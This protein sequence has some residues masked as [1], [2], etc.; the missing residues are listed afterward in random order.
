MEIETILRD[1]DNEPNWRHEAAESMDFYDSLQLTADELDILEERGMEPV[2][3]NVIFTGINALLGMEEK[4]RQDWRIVAGDEPDAD[5][6]VALS[7]KLNEE[8]RLSGSDRACSD[9]FASQVKVGIGWGEIRD[10]DDPFGYPTVAES[11]RWQ[12]M[13]WD[14]RARHP[15]LDDARYLVRRKW[16]DEDELTA[17]FPQHAKLIDQAVNGW[18]SWYSGVLEPNMMAYSEA[19]EREANWGIDEAEWRDGDR[20]RLALFEVWYR[21]IVAG[22]VLRVPEIGLVVEFDKKNP[23]HML[24][25]E[26]GRGKVKKA[27]IRRVRRAYWVGPHKMHD[28]PSPYDH[29]YF[30]YVPFFAFRE[31]SSGKPYGLIRL[32]KS[33]QREANRRL[34]KMDWLLNAY[35][36]IGDQDAFMLDWK[37]VVQEA[38]R[39]DAALPLNPKR[40]NRGHKPEIKEH[41]DMS[42][43]QFNVLQDSLKWVSEVGGIYQAM[44]G[45]TS[46][47]QSGVAINSLVEQGST[48]QGELF[49]N[50]RLARTR[51][52]ELLLAQTKRHL[53]GREIGVRIERGSQRKTV[54]FN[55]READGSVSNALT[56]L[57]MRVELSDV[58]STPTFRAAMHNQLTDLAKSLPANIQAVLI[59]TIVRGTDLP[60]KDEVARLLE[61]AMGQSPDDEGQEAD[62]QQAQQQQDAAQ[63][64]QLQAQLLDRT[65][66]ASA[67]E[68][69][70][71]AKEAVAKAEKAGIEVQQLQAQVQDMAD[72]THSADALLAAAMQ[73]RQMMATQPAAVA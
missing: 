25:A 2:V 23:M 66:V 54:V 73:R 43:Q 36:L 45:K 50:Y 48:T 40:M 11:P 69:E 72:Q 64:D 47:Q 3:R 1:V 68:A 10:N 35:R 4:A 5:E 57:R 20:R 17:R 44:M 51:M 39:P 16:F 49:G 71:K 15:L 27:P 18:P 31:D 12:E 24:L 55:Q 60:N 13:W 26:S 30:P 22:L 9:A 58:P 8:E 56:A 6:S 65:A 59:P 19:R 7:K 21:Q 42:A 52:G 38:G 37:Q 14:W 62:P 61:Q 46:D 32:Q 67:T 33:P 53:E 34:S 63:R 29:Q 28:A 41:S 70:A